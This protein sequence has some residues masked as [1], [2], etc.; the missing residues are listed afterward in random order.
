[1]KMRMPSVPLFNI[2]PYF[3]VWSSR[4]EINKSYPVHWTGSQNAVVGTVSVDGRKY[5]FLGSSDDEELKQVSIDID[6]M[7]TTAVFE[8]DK[9][10]LKAV[11]TSPLLITDLYYVSRP[12]S[13]LELS[14]ESADGAE[15]QVNARVTVGEELVLNRAGEGRA[16]SYTAEVK[17]GT[18]VKM[19]NGGQKVL[20]RSGDDVR[21]DWG[22]FYLAVRGEGR[23]ETVVFDSMYGISIEAPVNKSAL[24]AFAYDDIDSLIYFGKPVK[25]YWKKDGKTI[26]DAIAEAFGDYEQI[27][28]RCR[29]FSGELKREACEK[30]GEEYAELLSLAYRQVMAGHKL[31]VDEDGGLLYISKECFSNGCAATVDVTY[32]S[33]PMYLKYNPELLKAMLRPVFKYSRTDGWNF[34]FAPHDLGQYP[35]LNGQVYGDNLPQMQMPVEECGNMIILTAALCK[36]EN[37]T[38]FAEENIDLLRKWSKYLIDYG[39]DPENQL[40]TDD[41]A[42]HLA[43]NCNLAIKAIMGIAGYSEI[44]AA[45][46][47]TGE[48]QKYMSAAREYAASVCER[49]KNSDGSCRLAFDRPGTFSLKYNAVWDKIWATGLFGSEFFEGEI[50]RY[51]NEALPYGVPLD[52]RE[53]YTK[54]DWL[55]WAACLTENREDF[56][57]F[58]GLLWNSYNTT[59]KR[60]P[61]T[62][63]YYADTSDAI[64]F[65]HRTVQGGLFLKLLM[66]DK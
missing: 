49:A 43:H 15:H 51:K 44:L 23:A 21:I 5:R 56:E 30:G 13:Y 16:L 27:S 7:S 45:M 42:G 50:R 52:S 10:R 8:N 29:R 17:N 36:A 63:W 25:A 46:G 65:Q 35:I 33:S 4:E 32:P 20:W 26:E 6:A 55:I 34:D 14:Y 19:G 61:M 58:A 18:A 66:P 57:F 24:F 47:R 39:R 2:D 59:H 54:S 62:D 40:C 31:A 22:Y 28:E 12:V 60:V 9:I 1:M 38:G 41:F 37:S 3:S 48:A 64:M 11:F 53:K